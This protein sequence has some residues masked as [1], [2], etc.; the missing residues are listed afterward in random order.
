MDDL[1]F[2]KSCLKADKTAWKEFLQKYSRLIYSYIYNV[3][4]IKGFVSNPS[5]AEEI[6]NE[7][8]SLLIRDNFKKLRTYQG[9]NSASLASWLR[10][11]TINFCLTYLRGEKPEMVSLDAPVRGGLVLSEIISYR[12]SSAVEELIKKEENELLTECIQN[13]DLDEKIFLELKLSWAL[14][15]EELKDFLGISRGAADMRQSRIIQRLKDC[16]KTKGF[17][18]Q[19]KD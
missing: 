13:L 18:F 17:E 6:F 16:F 3:I 7:I 8:I 10:Q 2:V 9:R 19:E 11:V 12:S 14:N 15:L 1:S 5:C 4:R